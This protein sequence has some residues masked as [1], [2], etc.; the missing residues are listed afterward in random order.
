MRRVCLQCARLLAHQALVVVP[1]VTSSFIR[2]HLPDSHFGNGPDRD[3]VPPMFTRLD[4]V[5]ATLMDMRWCGAVCAGKD[6]VC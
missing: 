5:G 4:S 1:L 3:T 6:V 2:I